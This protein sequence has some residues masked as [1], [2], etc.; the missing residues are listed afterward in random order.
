MIDIIFW[1][2]PVYCQSGIKIQSCGT[3]A[4]DLNLWAA[5]LTNSSCFII[6]LRPDCSALPLPFIT[7]Y[8]PGNYQAGLYPLHVCVCGRDR[9]GWCVGPPTLRSV[10][11]DSDLTK[12]SHFTFEFCLNRGID[13]RVCVQ[14]AVAGCQWEWEQ[15]LQRKIIVIITKFI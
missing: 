15:L 4:A 1:F 7:V 2:S 14:T 11:H 10:W 9:T 3:K 8:L 13:E 12:S 5:P 6:R